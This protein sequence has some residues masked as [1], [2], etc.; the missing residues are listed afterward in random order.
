LP[1]ALVLLV[2]IFIT[3]LPRILN[4]AWISDVIANTALRSMPENFIDAL[5]QNILPNVLYTL[6]A[7][8]HFLHNSHY[9]TGALVDPITSMLLLVGVIGMITIMFKR[10]VIL[11]LLVS[12]FCAV[13]VIG[14]LVPYAYPAHTRTLLLVTFYSVF[15]ALGASYLWEAVRDLGLKL[16][17]TSRNVAFAAV[18]ALVLT[19]NLYQFFVISERKLYKISFDY[20]IREFQQHPPSTNFYYVAPVPVDY[21]LMMVL[22]RH[23]YNLDRWRPVLEPSEQALRE[24][25][26]TADEP[27][28]V[29]VMMEGEGTQELAETVQSVWSDQ[30]PEEVFDGLGLFRFTVFDV[31]ASSE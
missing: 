15:A 11:W 14:S 3:A 30:T 21:N 23:G 18:V 8:L 7:S 16:S 2:G 12:F 5:M 10:A 17:F 25:R 28:T 1:L 22:D 31:P 6:T 4:T 13:V 20:V 19:L 9:V 26:E 29:L 27:Y 24:I